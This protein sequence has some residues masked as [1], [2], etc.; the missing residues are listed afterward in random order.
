MICGYGGLSNGVIS[1]RTWRYIL[2]VYT[3]QIRN[4]AGT[5]FLE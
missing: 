1:P 2:I 4:D 5:P 3:I